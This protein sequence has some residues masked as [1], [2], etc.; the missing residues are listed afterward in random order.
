MDEGEHVAD[1]VTKQQKARLYRM[2]VQ[3]GLTTAQIDEERTVI[4]RRLR[5]EGVSIRAVRQARMWEILAADHLGCDLD[6]EPLPDRVPIRS[7]SVP[8]DDSVQPASVPGWRF[9]ISRAEASDELAAGSGRQSGYAER[10]EWVSQHLDTLSARPHGPLQRCLVDA[11]VGDREPEGFL[12]AAKAADGPPRTGP[13]YDTGN[14]AGLDPFPGTDA[15]TGLLATAR[16]KARSRHGPDLFGRNAGRNVRLNCGTD[17]KKR[18]PRRTRVLLNRFHQFSPRCH[19][20]VF[21][22]ND[23]IQDPELT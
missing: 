15:K 20:H 2:L 3:T 17:C 23:Q 1:C 9:R 12:F 7:R 10:V 13:R 14:Q 5:A 8:T 16:T 22:R 4:V 21:R 19:S 18:S 6:G 11:A